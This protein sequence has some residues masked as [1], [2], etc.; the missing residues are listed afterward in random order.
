MAAAERRKQEQNQMRNAQP[1]QG[2]PSLQ[3]HHHS[4]PLPG[5]QPPLSSH[6]SMGRPSLDRAHTFPT[7]PTSASSV[8]GSMGASDNFQ[9]GQQG[10]SGGQGQNPMPIDTGLSNARSMPTTPATTPPGTSIQSLQSYPPASQPYDSTRP[11]YNAPP[12]Q[13]SP[14]PPV[15]TSSQERS[16]Y[17]STA[18]VKSEMGPPTSRP[19]GAEQGDVKAPNGLM[20]PGQSGEAVHPHS[21]P[22]EEADHEHDAEYTHD[23]G[24][25]DASRGPYNYS[26]PPV[27]SLP[28]DHQH[29]TPEMTG[30]PHQAGSERA[31]PRTA[32]APPSYYTQQGYNT[33]PPRAQQ[34]PSSLY[35]VMSNERGSTNGGPGNDVYGSQ[36][37]MASSMQNGYGSHAP[38]M[39][40][41]SGGLKRGRD[42][43]DDK[44]VT[45]MPLDLKRRKT[46]LDGSMPSPTYSNPIAPPTAAVAA[47]RRR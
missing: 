40:G 2:L 26:A 23:S 12:P 6:G 18:Y 3:H 43:D 22:E 5:P 47:Q 11:M 46:M 37:E 19:T 8:M 1:P 34:P 29:L 45:G 36:S 24:A 38:I 32:A 4:I 33:T 13:Q 41:G 31:T 10:M 39:N 44:S 28:S 20:Q 9:W 7:P 27:S 30:S 25:Y 21:G 35:N 17:G 14:Y 42:D 15:N 16:L